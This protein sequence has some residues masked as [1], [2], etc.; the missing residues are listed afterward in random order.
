MQP[1]KKINMAILS[2]IY[3][4]GIWVAIPSFALGV[5]LLVRCITGVVRT[6]RE[7]RLFSVPLLDRQEIDFVEAGRVVLAMEGPLFSRRFAKLHYELTGPDGMAVTGRSVLFRATTTGLTKARM[8]LKVYKIANPGRHV[9]QIRGLGGAKPS[10]PEHSMVFMRPHLGR[11]V[12]YILGII[13]AAFFTVGSIV[14]FSL[15]LTNG[16]GP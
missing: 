4:N 13:L 1:G 7:A 15:R 9:F 10:D 11:T 3:T 5:M 14:L 2:F 12:M 16:N 8:E 6:V